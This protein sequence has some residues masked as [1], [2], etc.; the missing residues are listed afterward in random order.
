MGTRGEN[1]RD[2][3][4]QLALEEERVRIAELSITEYARLPELI[5]EFAAEID[6]IG[7]NP[8]KGF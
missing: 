2:K 4:T 8:F 7:L 1:I 5:D 3:L 6:E